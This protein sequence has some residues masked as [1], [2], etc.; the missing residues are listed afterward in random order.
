M[1]LV[2]PEN[3][4]PGVRRLFLSLQARR[5][6]NK[7]TGSS[8]MGSRG[9]YERF[10]FLDP[11]LHSYWHPEL[12]WQT[13]E[14]R[15]F[16]YHYADV[17]HDLNV[18]TQKQS[19]TSPSAG[20]RYQPA[21]SLTLRTRWS[22]SF[23]PPVWSDQFATCI[24]P[25]PT[26]FCSPDTRFRTNFTGLDPYHPDGPTEISIPYGD[27]IRQ[28]YNTNL[29]NEFSDT[30][31]VGFDW[32]PLAIPGLRWTVDWSKTDFTNRIE[33]SVSIQF[34]SQNRPELVMNH[35]QLITRDEQGEIVSI[36]FQPINVNAKLSEILDTSLQYSFETPY[37][38]FTPRVGY[39]RILADYVQISDEETSRIDFAGTQLGPDKYQL[40]GSLSWLWNRF[41]ADVF[42]YY[43]PGYVHERARYC[44]YTVQQIP[45]NRCEEIPYEYLSLDVDSL[46]T[47][48]LTVTLRMDNGLRVRVGGRN[49]LDQAAPA[50]VF[51]GGLPYDPTR[52]DA[53]GQ[54]F[55]VDL[56]WEM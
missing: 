38:Q 3:S 34:M 37:G 50:T 4:L 36:L 53:R 31:S 2:S 56:N 42:V 9:A 12:G 19:R 16:R 8:Y 13:Y 47:V 23:R 35:P 6:E 48:D 43:T 27:V 32:T 18:N 11:K 26:S 10:E 25:P 7:Q 45:G 15:Q 46:I 29:D 14:Q 1:P 30:W 40:Q 54:V 22:R 51:G 41:A 55:F 39:T 28:V 52:W 5:D 17:V 49:V 33:D 21:D 24:D 20:L 44:S